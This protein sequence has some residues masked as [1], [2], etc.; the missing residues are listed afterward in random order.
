M[1]YEEMT[2][3]QIDEITR[4]GGDQ[5]RKLNKAVAD[6]LDGLKLSDK[7]REQIS[8]TDFNNMADV[9]GG[10]FTSE[11]VEEVAKQAYKMTFE[12]FQAEALEGNGVENDAGQVWVNVNGEQYTVD[13]DDVLDHEEKEAFEA[14]AYL[15]SHLDAEAWDDLYQQY[16]E[17]QGKYRKA[18]IIVAFL[19][20]YNYIP[21]R[22]IKA[23]YTRCRAYNGINH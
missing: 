17:D 6:Y 12:E 15:E 21:D 23:I 7:A 16:L 18:T 22:H 19:L 9:F 2:M 4:R 13:V 14:S 3:D 20:I 11:E 5:L 8:Q 1:K 10:C